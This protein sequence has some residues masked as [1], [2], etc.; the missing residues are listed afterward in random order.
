MINMFRAD[1][2]RLIRSKGFYIAMLILLVTIGVSVYFVGPGHI[3]LSDSSGTMSD[4]VSVQLQT[5]M[6]Q[7]SDEELQSVSVSKFREIMLSVKGYELDRD[8]LS[9]NMNLYYIFIFI[10]AIIL[11][12]DFS[13]GSVKN[14]LSSAIS[15]NKF[16]LSKLCLITLCCTAILFLNTYIVYFV[17]ILFNSKSLAS[18]LGAVTEVTLLQLPPTLALASILTGIGFMTKKTSLFN[19]ITI[20][21]IMVSQIVL[22]VV[23][24]IFEIKEEYLYYEFQQMLRRLANNPSDSYILHSFFVCAVVIVVFNLLGYLSFRK[25]EIK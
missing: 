14:T 13:G 8:I 18:S 7:L 12:V 20:P 15:R 1:L 24:L 6:S 2:Y 23:A 9:V 10:A 16:Y 22:R 3:G 17:N 19:I 4:D 11:T 21:L 5:A 25:A